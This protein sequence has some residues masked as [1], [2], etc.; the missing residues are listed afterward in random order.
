MSWQFVDFQI[1]FSFFITFEDLVFLKVS[2]TE[3]KILSLRLDLLQ[4][5]RKCWYHLES[6]QIHSYTL[7]RSDDMYLH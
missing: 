7:I 2:G 1:F 4:H 3:F 6:L 5:N